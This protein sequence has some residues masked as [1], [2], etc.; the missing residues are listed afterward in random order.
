MNEEGIGM[1]ILHLTLRFVQISV[2]YKNL[3]SAWPGIPENYRCKIKALNISSMK[4]ITLKSQPFTR[5]ARK[6]SRLS[7]T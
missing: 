3:I 1:S 4:K 6:I 7:V 2:R 5:I